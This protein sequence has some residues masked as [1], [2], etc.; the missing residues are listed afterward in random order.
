MVRGQVDFAAE[1][2]EQL[3]WLASSLRSS[4]V[5]NGLLACFPEI[6][7]FQIHDENYR[8]NGTVHAS[9]RI[10]CQMDLAQ[11]ISSSPGFCWANLFRNP[12]LVTG[13]PIRSRCASD[14][15]LELSLRVLAQLVDSRQLTSIGERIILKGFSSLLVATA[16][17]ADAVLWHLVFNS[18][19]ERISYCDSRLESTNYKIAEEFTLRHLETRRHIVGWCSH[20][21]ELSG[22]RAPSPP[23][24][25]V[26]NRRSLNRPS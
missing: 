1:I 22:K 8:P 17:V 26:L 25:C 9:C 6:S 15:G 20:V 21:R 3:G 12:L 16:V 7:G 11:E 2:A 24:Q 14:T 18:T 23:L 19:G 10:D 5:S 4:P 13:Y